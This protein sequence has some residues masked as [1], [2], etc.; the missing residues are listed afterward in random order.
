[1][2]SSAGWT[3]TWATSGAVRGLPE[4]PNGRSHRKP[5]NA[6]ATGSR[7]DPW[8]PDSSRHHHPS[9][10]TDRPGRP[11]R[12]RL[13][14]PLA[15]ATLGR[16]CRSRPRPAS[17]QDGG[18]SGAG[19][20]RRRV[21]GMLPRAIA[22]VAC[23]VTWGHSGIEAADPSHARPPAWAEMPPPRAPQEALRSM[24]VKP[25]LRIEL[26]ASEPLVIDPV[27]IDFGADGRLWVCE[28][29][30]YPTGIDGHWTPGGVIKSL[31]DRDGDG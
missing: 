31:E 12:R 11:P 24:R 15:L 6:S 9:S 30:D 23:L 3:T 25:G 1:M 20:S 28:M 4:C 10:R 17:G 19:A 22:V 21:S 29:R 16:E 18:V 13:T 27:A 2:S 26:V 14:Y 8:H 7:T 5:P